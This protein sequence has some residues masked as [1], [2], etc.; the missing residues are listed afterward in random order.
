MIS[1]GTVRSTLFS[2]ALVASVLTLPGVSRAQLSG[3]VTWNGWTF[4]YEVS[5][6]VDGLSLKGVQ[7]QGIPLINKISVPV[8]RVFYDNNACGPFAD[9]LGQNLAPIPWAG[10]AT[11]AQREFTLNGRQWYEIGIRPQIG[12]YDMYQVY[13]LSADGILDAHIFSKGLACVVNHVHYPNWRVDFDIIDSGN[14]RIQQNTVAGYQTKLIEFNANATEA[15]NHGW[16]VR[17]SVTGNFVDVLPGFTDFTIPNETTQ[18]ETSYAGN[19]VFGRLFRGSEDTGW[20]YG[21]NTQVPYNNGESIDNADIVLWYEGYLPHLAAEGSSLWH[22][23]G[24]RL[25][26][27]GG[28]PDTTPPTAPTAL[29]VTAAGGSQ[30]TL[31]WTASTD[32]IGVT[33]YRVERCQGAGCSSFSQIATPVG[34]TYP[35]TG[36]QA[37]TSYSYR[38]RATDAAGNL[39]GYSTTATV[40]TGPPDTTPPTVP[41]GLTAAAPGSSQINLSWTASTDNIGVTGYQVERCQGAGCTTFAQ[42]ATPTA[43]SYSDAG[44]TPG[45]SYSYRVR[46]TDAAGNVSQDYSNV[47]SASTPITPPGLVAAYAFNEGTGTTVTDASGSGNTGT[48]N[49]ATRT[50]V[51]RFGGALVFNGTSARVDVPDAPS[52]D[53]TT[54]MTLAAWVYPTVAATAWRD[55]IFK[56]VDMYYLEASSDNAGRPGAGGTFASPLYGAAP[57]PTNTW[58]YLAVTYEGATLRLYVNGTQ[59]ASRV[60][61]GA[62]ATSSGALSIGGDA[63]FGQYFQGRIDEVRIYNRA[64][65]LAEIQQDMN[66]PVGV[67]P[68][69]TTP[70][71]VP[72]GLTATVAGSSQINLTWTASTDTVGVTGYRVE[73]CQGAGCSSFAQVATPSGTTYSDTG[74]TAGTSYS[75]QVRATDAAGNLSGYSNTAGATTN[76]ALSG[77]VAAYGFGEGVGTTVSDASGNGNGGALVGATWTTQGKY[78]NAL[79]F[80]GTSGRVDVP[81][82]PSLDLTTGM[83]LAAWV[84]PTVAQTG[85]RDVIFKAVDMYYLEASSDIANVPGAGG[86][87]APTPLYATAQLLANTWTHLAVTYDGA[88]LR[89]YVNG[90]QVSSRAQ[91]GAIRTSTGPLTIGGDATFGQYFQGRIDEVRVY[92]RALTAAQIQ[93]DMNTPIVVGPPDLTAPTDPSGLTATAAGS[94]QINL[95][96]TAST[97][98]VGVTGYLV[99]RCQGAGCSSFTQI[100]T[101]AGISYFDTGL[102]ASTSY[103]Y[104]VRATDAA[105]NLSGYSNTA[106]ATTATPATVTAFPGA[107]AI[108]TGSLQGGSSAS[109]NADDNNYYVVNSTTSGTPTSSWYGI[110]TG[111][112]NNLSNLKVTYKGKN[113]R[114]CTQT[115]AIWRWTD[116]TWVQ[117]D[118]RSVNTSEIQIADLIPPGTQSDYVSGTTGDG[119]LRVRVRCTGNS[120]SFSS[121]GD[122]M[123]MVYDVIP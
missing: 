33:S 37:L 67:G 68:P 97:D 120:Q 109:L 99:E 92:N 117:L 9:R 121:S 2:G 5:G 104:R 95:S 69:D 20:T 4:T 64:L 98:T 39:S 115:V 54:G 77:L 8:V 17:D 27:N 94:S 58:T 81:D 30:I 66:T 108:E 103:S 80:N 6:N 60:Q 90:I 85:W 105:G 113:S 48:I 65:S 41:T 55:V 25:A 47:A 10:N 118:S 89:L 63:A 36:L 114:K 88:M 40:T 116:S 62:I 15:I 73:R 74:L 26:V 72:T 13:Y 78:G 57:L 101:P 82:A 112:S 79:V 76:A 70:P 16:R 46:A 59:V 12:N 83:T 31:S 45:T 102:Q 61:T 111:V 53:L 75:Y 56:A 32:N 3:S 119:E 22:S 87:F 50:T 106:S 110:F 51:G 49:G 107:T 44:L 93:T 35:D 24:I 100:A 52:L 19:T 91:T 21:P 34:T 71:T 18:P 122:L 123:K 1:A 96:W 86:T 84:N 14:D 43:N 7:F 11:I 23:T 42:I 29:T 38:V 28:S